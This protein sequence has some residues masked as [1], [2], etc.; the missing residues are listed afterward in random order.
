MGA[1][2][3]GLN[4]LTAMLACMPFLFFASICC[5]LDWDVAYLIHLSAS[6]SPAICDKMSDYHALLCMSLHVVTRFEASFSHWLWQP[7]FHTRFLADCRHV[8]ILLPSTSST[9]AQILNAAA[10][11]AHEV[12]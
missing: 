9:E 11:I 10:P 8:A 12:L 4:L 6:S 2:H 3:I 5:T 1:G 7:V